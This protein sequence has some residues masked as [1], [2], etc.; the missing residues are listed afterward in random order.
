MK[1]A[2]PGRRLSTIPC[3]NAQDLGKLRLLTTAGSGWSTILQSFWFRP[4]SGESSGYALVRSASTTRGLWRSLVSALDWGS[5][6]PG[7]KSRQ[8]DHESAGQRP[9]AL[10]N[11]RG[12]C[13]PVQPKCNPR[14]PR[15]VDEALA[16]H[17][18]RE[19][20]ARVQTAENQWRPSLSHLDGSR[21]Q[22][23]GRGNSQATPAHPGHRQR[24]RSGACRPHRSWHQLRVGLRSGGFRNERAHWHP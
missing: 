16:L 12:R 10:V 13:G 6:G 17:E 9:C 2:F 18:V 8:P 4:R 19:F 3:G 7:F 5:R 24:V 21:A 11:A 15:M 23:T 22:I 14:L 20:G 1:S